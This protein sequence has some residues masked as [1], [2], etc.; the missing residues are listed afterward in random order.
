MKIIY[1]K[2][3]SIKGY[4]INL[5]GVVVIRTGE[6]LSPARLRHEQ[7]HTLQMRELLYVFFYILY[8]FEWL[9]KLLPHGRKSY[10]NISFEREAYAN[11][12]DCEYLNKR[13]K[14]SWVKYIKT[15]ES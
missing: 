10:Y 12:Q 6:F 15:K 5:F 3:F 8:L 14:Y 9:F 4:A 7:I 11:E 2:I 13:T 1:S